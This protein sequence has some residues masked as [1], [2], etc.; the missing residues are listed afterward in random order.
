M[1][2]DMLKMK[3]FYVIDYIKTN[4]VEFLQ[5]IEM[6]KEVLVSIFAKLYSLCL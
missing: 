4:Y 1:L 2:L 3:L 5:F 6:A